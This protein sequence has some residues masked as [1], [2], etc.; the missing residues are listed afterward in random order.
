MKVVTRI[1]SDN[2]DAL[3]RK[4]GGRISAPEDGDVSRVVWLAVLVVT[5]LAAGVASADGRDGHFNERKSA[6]FHLYQDVAIERYSG[7][8]GWRRFELQLLEILEHAYDQVGELLGIWPTHDTRVIVYDP[9]VFDAR[10]A[11]AFAFRA[12]GFYDGAIHVRGGTEITHGLVGTLHHE[13]TH[14]AVQSEAGPG[15]FPA[16][17]NEG[18]AEYVEG[19]ALG[20]RRLSPGQYRVLIGS[21]QQGGW[22]PLASLSSP[23]L[24]HLPDGQ[25]SLAYLESHALVEYLARRYGSERL[26]RLCEELTR[27]RNMERALERSYH[28]TLAE[29]EEELRAELLRG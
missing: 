3:E 11:N 12:V 6:H 29:L 18:L 20:H 14:A 13:Y 22:I 25:A 8:K 1:P 5:G 7:P 27:T 15:L 24:A 9:E 2:M 17:L 4:G 10:Y 19:R 23:S 21:L 26:R 16:W 28:K